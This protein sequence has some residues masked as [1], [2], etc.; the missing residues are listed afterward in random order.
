MKKC[1]KIL[2][3]FMA[4]VMVFSC[5]Q[6]SVFA[7][8]RDTSSLDAYL[9][10]DNLA[11]IVETLLKDLDARKEAIVP[12][13][14]ELVFMLDALKNQAAADGID[15]T[16]ASAETYSKVLLNYLDDMLEET[17]LNGQ[18]GAY[19]GL[20]GMVLGGVT[21][22]LNSVDGFISTLVGLIKTFNDGKAK[23]W[24]TLASFDSSAL[25][26]GKKN[27]KPITRANGDLEV[28]YALFEWLAD[29]TGVL[30]TVIKGELSLGSMN[31]TVKTATGM[32][33][34]EAIDAQGMVNELVG[35]LDEMIN[36]ELYNNLV[37]TWVTVDNGDGTTSRKIET[38][39]EDSQYK[40]FSADE[41]LGAALVKL[42]T[43]KD[44][45]QKTAADTAKMTMGELLGKYGDYV[46][47]SFALDPLNNDLK[48]ALNDLVNNN[49]DFAILKNIINL[50]YEFEVTDF[51][52]TALAKKGIFEGLNDLVC[53]IIGVIV[54]PSVAA[55][56]ALKKG[57]NENITANLTSFF[58][59]VLKTLSTVNGGK[60]AVEIE[61]TK[62][63][64]D[65]S[66]FTA[67]NLAK[68][69]LE[70]MVIGVLRLFTPMAIGSELPADIDT[71]ENVALFAA[72]YAIDVFMVQPEECA[73]TTDY[74]DL[75]YNTDGTIKDLSYNKW[76]DVMGTM[77]MDVADY[78]LARAE[79]GYTTSNADKWEGIFEDIVDWALNYIKG[80]P[81]VADELDMEIGTADGYGPW[82]KLNVVIN[83]LLPL[84][85]INGCG[86]ET[87]VVDTYNLVIGKLVPSL[88][89]CDFAAFADVLSVNN[90]PESLFNKS[91]ISG[92][93]GLVDNLLFS[94]FEH[95]CGKTATFTK[96]ATA[97]HDG[98]TGTYCTA[99]GHYDKVTV[100]P[101]TGVTEPDPPV[102]DPDPP[103]VDPDPPVVDP[104]P[105][106]E[107]KIL[108][109]DVTGDGKIVAA[110]ARKALRHSAG[111]DILTGDAL[112]AADVTKDG[113]VT[114]SD[115]RKILRHSAG[116]ELIVQA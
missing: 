76:V 38:A 52:F 45:D 1:T 33:L 96:A 40:N 104:D 75:V 59:Y 16:D 89:D 107:N 72:Y 108:I 24:G 98:Y 99:N 102:V 58:S 54:Q 49:A 20:I 97:T 7:A 86:D 114:A 21:V 88:F 84:N 19:S 53:G 85:F 13:I 92:V 47:A 42:M 12:T 71:L 18:L 66:G 34:D 9:D 113:K 100:T 3:V 11:V 44:V 10:N 70:D 69:N 17:D 111:L 39:Y 93:I 80:L 112:K 64:F 22:E 110:D 67:A 28:V 83:E 57:G 63:E 26:T 68:M 14:L 15:L 73:F 115:A 87:F 95:E 82:Y 46:I 77:A 27:P 36:K 37:A 35:G 32:F 25:V 2:S 41:L 65:F 109:G 61:G 78:W 94:L 6:V 106:V 60:I 23:K 62:Y 81:A 56:L 48:K 29:N 8:E 30:K 90:D 79:V 91:V 101:A 43:G 31:A 50:D 5:M 55:E 116:L 4:L 74:K 105:P 103:V 51:N